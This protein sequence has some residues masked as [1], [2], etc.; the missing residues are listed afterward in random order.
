MGPALWDLPSAFT[1]NGDGH[2]DVFKLLYQGNIN[3]SSIQIFNRWGAIVFE[4]K[5]IDQGWD[6]R[7]NGS[8]APSD[9]YVY[10]IKLN[11]GNDTKPIIGDLTLIR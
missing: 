11:V 7:H 1:P 5:D 3:L 9:V 6:G 10:V 4:T 8:L 2:N